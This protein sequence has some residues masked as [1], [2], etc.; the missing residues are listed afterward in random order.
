MSYFH[1]LRNQE[2]L[3]LLIFQTNIIF[4]TL[5]FLNKEGKGLIGIGAVISAQ[6]N[7]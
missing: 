6:I 4:F 2:H 5:I 3:Y 1:G 7:T